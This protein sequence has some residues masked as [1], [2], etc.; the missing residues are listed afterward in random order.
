MKKSLLV[1][2]TALLTLGLVS[3]GETPASCPTCEECPTA[4]E[5]L[6]DEEGRTYVIN[7]EDEEGNIYT[8]FVKDG[9]YDGFGKIEY[10]TGTIYTG[11]FK[12]GQW[13][14][15]GYINWD[16]GCIYIGETQE[17]LMWGIGYMLW[18]MGDYYVGE[19]SKGNPNGWG[20]K[21]YMVDATAE[22]NEARYNYY[23]GTM[24]NNYKIGFGMMR[25]YFGDF[26][27]GDWAAD[28]RQGQGEVYW[29]DQALETMKFVGTF[30]NDWING[31]GTM[32]YRDG[33]II[34]GFWDGVE[35]DKDQPYEVLNEGPKSQTSSIPEIAFPSNDPTECF[36]FI[37]NYIK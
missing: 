15:T 10:T 29:A 2:T 5:G 33:R 31:E 22:K 16:S 3:C 25:Y 26:Y 12:D 30:K 36:D 27:I 9:L 34:H 19:W 37:N 14:G 32:Y 6:T 18:T 35:L 20:M 11:I 8:G 17:S 23:F 7:Q 13:N 4:G 24:K 1:L 28:C 21:G